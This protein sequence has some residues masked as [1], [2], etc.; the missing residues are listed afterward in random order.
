MD[1]LFRRAIENARAKQQKKTIDRLTAELLDLC[2]T[3]EPDDVNYLNPIEDDIA[4]C[5]DCFPPIEEEFVFCPE[6]KNRLQCLKALEIQITKK[7]YYIQ[8]QQT[9][10][11]ENVNLVGIVGLKEEK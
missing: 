1:K 2:H 7:L 6:C 3:S 4:V 8:N 10:A 5:P 9:E 11:E